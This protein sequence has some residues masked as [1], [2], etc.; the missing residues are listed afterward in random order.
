MPEIHTIILSALDK[1]LEVLDEYDGFCYY[2]KLLEVMVYDFKDR[3]IK[4]LYFMKKVEHDVIFLSSPL[5][6]KVS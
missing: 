4:P 5:A 3:F 1:E 6:Q 2:L